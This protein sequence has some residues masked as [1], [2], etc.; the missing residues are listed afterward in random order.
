MGN[1]PHWDWSDDLVDEEDT[2]NVPREVLQSV[3][4]RIRA[5]E[6]LRER[7]RRALA[8]QAERPPEPFE[9]DAS[10]DSPPRTGDRLWRPAAFFTGVGLF[11]AVPTA[12]IWWMLA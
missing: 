1:D 6:A 2:G 4:R 11:A 7:A 5:E 9:L 3:L 10:L 12:I 8:A